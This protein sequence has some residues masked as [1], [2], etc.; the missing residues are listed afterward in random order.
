MSD[1]IQRRGRRHFLRGIGG[2]ALALPFME[3]LLGRT[4]AAAPTAATPRFVGLLSGHG[5]LWPENMYPGD[6]MLDQTQSL[7]TGHVARWGALQRKIEGDVAEL[8]AVLR[9]DASLLTD[10]LASKLMVV[11]GLDLAFKMGHCAS[12]A[13]G[14]FADGND[15]ANA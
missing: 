1:C 2:F 11:R 12:G 3:S 13:L 15:L 9:A 10:A 4:A 8:S 7:Y 5:G 6:A 14:N